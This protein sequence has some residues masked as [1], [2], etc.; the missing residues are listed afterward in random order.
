[1]TKS[2][3]LMMTALLTFGLTAA[4]MAADAPTAG[5]P[6]AADTT[7]PAPSVK[8]H[9]HS[10]KKHKKATTASSATK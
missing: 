10:G 2:A 4:S 9:K 1:M 5:T 8:S 3:T 6:A 7:A